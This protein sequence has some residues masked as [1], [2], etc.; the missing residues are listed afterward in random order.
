MLLSTNEGAIDQGGAALLAAAKNRHSDVV[1]LLLQ[2]QA[3]TNAALQAL[4]AKEDAKALHCLLSCPEFK[5]SVD[6]VQQGI[7]AVATRK[8][9][10]DLLLSLGRAMGMW[11]G[12][13]PA[14]SS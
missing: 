1:S 8:K 3:N 14:G 13:D 2:R 4:I 11:G 9:S 7:L 5:A 10:F 12:D 6:E